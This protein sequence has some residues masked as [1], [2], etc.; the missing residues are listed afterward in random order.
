MNRQH[1][2]S[3]R[4]LF[5]ALGSTYLASACAHRH[6]NLQR[7]FAASVA[8]IQTRIGGRVGVYVLDTQSQLELAFNARERFAMCSTFKL[9]L[10]AQ[11]CTE[12]MQAPSR[13]I[14]DCRCGLKTCCPTRR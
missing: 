1:F 12:W 13:S 10:A 7:D 9:L 3:R 14:T 4:T 2:I 6:A 11:C 5:A 8:A